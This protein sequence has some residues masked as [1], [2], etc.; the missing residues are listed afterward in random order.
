MEA[1]EEDVEILKLIGVLIVIVGFILKFDTI[2]VVVVAGIVTGFVASMPPME[3][4]TV[5]GNSFVSQRLA[6]LFVLTLPL[7]GI[8]ERYGLKDKAV[9]FIRKTKRATSGG[10]ITIYL[11]IRTLAAA[12]SVRLGGHPQFVRP[13]IEPMANAAS[14]ARY[15]ELKEKTVDQIKGYSAGSENLGNFMAQNCFMGASGTLLIVSTLTEQGQNVNALQIALMSIPIAVFAVLVG[16]AHNRLFDRSL[17][18]TYGYKK[19][20]AAGGEA[21]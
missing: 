5:L 13:L 6:T 2:A 20:G 12:F 16:V 7:I 15:G 8:C 17:D 21:K 4:L 9:D 19:S 1:Q 10:I 11:V 14:V 3:I 18:K